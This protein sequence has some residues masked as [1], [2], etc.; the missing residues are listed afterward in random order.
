MRCHLLFELSK[1]SRKMEIWDICRCASR[2]CLSYNDGR[3]GSLP[4]IENFSQPPDKVSLNSAVQSLVASKVI[5]LY[6]YDLYYFILTHLW[7][8]HSFGSQSI[9]G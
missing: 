6:A 2:L 4:A 5:Y 3:W 1:I 8:S 9:S 7:C